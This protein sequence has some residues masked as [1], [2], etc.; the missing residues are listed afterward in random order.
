MS[1]RTI[2][3]NCPQCG[4]KQLLKQPNE[5][6]YICKRCHYELSDPLRL[7]LSSS[8]SRSTSISGKSVALSVFVIFGF[9]RLLAS[10]PNSS[11]DNQ[12][13]PAVSQ[14]S[15]IYSNSNSSS[16]NQSYPAS[17]VSA[18]RYPTVLYTPIPIENPIYSHVNDFLPS[19][20]DDSSNVEKKKSPPISSETAAPTPAVTNSPTVVAQNQSLPSST[21]LVSPENGGRGSLKVINDT[22]SDAYIKLVE[23]SSRSLVGALY[24]KSNSTFSLKHIPDGT[25]EVL[26]ALGENWDKK[27]RSF[28]VT[29]Y[30]AKFDKSLEYTT[31]RSNNRIQYRAFQL[32]LNRVVGGNATTSSVGEQEF[33]SY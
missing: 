17:S 8:R 21:V 19:I 4:R 26:F 32:T 5:W 3:T 31:T 23:P 2:G 13:Y 7:D 12:S 1:G 22:D 27:T 16:D 14:Q 33:G 15:Q 20:S 25:Y 6:V 30:F 18:T 11:S 9:F 28:T 24:V 29:N 10:I